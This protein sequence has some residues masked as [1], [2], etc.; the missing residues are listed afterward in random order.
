[1]YVFDIDDG[2]LIRLRGVDF[3][4]GAK[5]FNIIASAKGKTTV[6]L[7]LDS[8]KGPVM[9]KV[10]ITPTGSS[11]DYRVFSTKVKKIAGVHDLYL[12][13]GNTTGDVRLDWW[14]FKK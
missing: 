10:N 6:T 14:Q 7:R 13:F 3:G 4:K 11:E 5:N 12:C 1:M 8:Q 9:G 2:E